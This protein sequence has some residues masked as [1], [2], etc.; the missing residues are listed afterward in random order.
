MTMI[1]CLNTEN[2][3]GC[4]RANNGGPLRM[5]RRESTSNLKIK[6]G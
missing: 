2:Q 5:P 6:D 4:A 1:V 3:G